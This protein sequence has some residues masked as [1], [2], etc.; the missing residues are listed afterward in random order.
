PFTYSIRRYFE[1]KGY[2]AAVAEYE[3]IKKIVYLAVSVLIFLLILEKLDELD[4]SLHKSF[5]LPLPIHELTKRIHP[6]I[7]YFDYADYLLVLIVSAG[8]F[9]MLLT[10]ERKKFRLFFAKR[11]FITAQNKMNDQ[12]NENDEVEIMGQFVKGFNS[13]NSYLRKQIKLHI[14]NIDNIYSKI[15]SLPRQVKNGIIN[16]VSKVFIEKELENNTLA[17][18]RCLSALMHLPDDQQLLAQTSIKLEIKDWAKLATI[19][20]S[21]IIAIQKIWL[22]G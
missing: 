16:D 15:I 22:G 20:I 11:Y 13:Y 5:S 9:K 3:I 18:V 14:E 17:P 2:P 12:S 21:L 10:V 4:A 8:L 6:H 19:I 1:K 7:D